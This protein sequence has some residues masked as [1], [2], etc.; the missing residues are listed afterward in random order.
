MT[1]NVSNL[2]NMEIGEN[3]KNRGILRNIRDIGI[4]E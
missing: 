3:R 4:Y 2:G 1:R